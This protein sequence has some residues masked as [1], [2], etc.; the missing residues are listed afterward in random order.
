MDVDE[1]NAY[2]TEFGISGSSSLIG[3]T[4][5]DAP[6]GISLSYSEETGKYTIS[7]TQSGVNAVD[8]GK[9]LTIRINGTDKTFNV[10]YVALENIYVKDISIHDYEVGDEGI[11]ISFI[12]SA[13]ED[14]ATLIGGATFGG[15]LASKITESSTAGNYV[16]TLTKDEANALLSETD[17]T[18]AFSGKEGNFKVYM[19]ESLV[20]DINTYS[21]SNAS[22][23]NPVA[24]DVTLGSESFTVGFRL[25][26]PAVSN[27]VIG[28]AGTA[29]HELFSNQTARN[30][31][32][33]GFSVWMKSKQSSNY[34]FGLSVY[35]A[36]GTIWFDYTGL[37]DFHESTAIV[38][39]EF[40]RSVD[41]KLTVKMYVNGTRIDESETTG[42]KAI[43]YTGSLDSGNS[44]VFGGTATS[45]TLFAKGFQISDIIV[46]KGL[47]EESVTSSLR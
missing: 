25:T 15:E 18:V 28:T 27:I 35:G 42:T 38:V 9:D 43:S 44:L 24:K 14:G 41:G 22:T 4:L 37:Q 47:S 13:D 30:T 16:L 21:S 26:L 39:A 2:S 17:V 33:S 40:D 19:L 23:S 29:N 8:G 5:V 20:Y 11:S 7:F 1:D 6:D 3:A 32:T 12:V 36:S 45:T 46:T 10:K 34:Q 31:T